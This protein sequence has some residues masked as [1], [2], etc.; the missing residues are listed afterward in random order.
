MSGSQL[1]VG[2]T[3]R[4]QQQQQG[5][6]VTWHAASRTEHT[7]SSSIFIVTDTTTEQVAAGENSSANWG[8]WF[9]SSSRNRQFKGDV[10]DWISS[11]MGK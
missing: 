11:K 7:L 9:A 6:G 4:E 2:E 5:E 10:Y 1:N 3:S 8:S